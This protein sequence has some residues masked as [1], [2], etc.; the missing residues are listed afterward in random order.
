MSKSKETISNTKELNEFLAQTLIDL[1]DKNIN[2]TIAKSVAQVADKINKNNANSIEYKRISSHKN[3]I[4][5]F[6]D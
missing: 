6:E 1:R 4:E 2:Y 5:F 3:P